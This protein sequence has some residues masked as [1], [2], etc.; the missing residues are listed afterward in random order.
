MMRFHLSAIAIQITTIITIIADTKTTIIPVI[1]I[2]F[3]FHIKN[4]TQKI[5]LADWIWSLIQLH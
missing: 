5:I 3:L 4:I 2:I 1:I